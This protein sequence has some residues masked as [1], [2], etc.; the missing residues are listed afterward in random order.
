M[1]QP[2]IRDNLFVVLNTSNN[3]KSD[4]ELTAPIHAEYCRIL[5]NHNALIQANFIQDTYV[6]DG[7]DTRAY[8]KSGLCFAGDDKTWYRLKEK[9]IHKPIINLY[10]NICFDSLALNFQFI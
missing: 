8:K 5:S 4:G 2:I 6:L 7:S 3:W 10:S 1:S 9:T